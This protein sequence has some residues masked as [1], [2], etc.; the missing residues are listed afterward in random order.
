GRVAFGGLHLHLLVRLDLNYSLGRRAILTVRFTPDFAAQY[1]N[2]VIHGNGG[3]G[4]GPTRLAVAQF[5]GVVE[6]IASDARLHLEPA[7]AIFRAH[8]YRA[9]RAGNLAKLPVRHGV[10]DKI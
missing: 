6:L 3:S 5:M 8:K 2:I 9:V 1:G 10:A 7:C 4:A